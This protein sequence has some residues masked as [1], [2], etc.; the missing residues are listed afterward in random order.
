VDKPVALSLDTPSIECLLWNYTPSPFEPEAVYTINGLV[1][2][3]FPVALEAPQSPFNV[4]ATVHNACTDT[5]VST[6]LLVIY[7][8]QVYI[9]SPDTALCT[10]TPSLPLWASDS[11]GIWSG[12]HLFRY[13]G[14]TWFNPVDTGSYQLIYTRGIGICLSR[15]T[16][17]I[18][19]APSDSIRAG[20]DII[21]M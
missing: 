11:T 7:P 9:L 4:V 6:T 13:Q 14:Q 3:S 5:T 21:R 20:A 17:N 15:D 8:E 10:E 1:R 19:V 18:R 16:M 12:A 2:D